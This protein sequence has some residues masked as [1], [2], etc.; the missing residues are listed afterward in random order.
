MF[1]LIIE[2]RGYVNIY[3]GSTWTESEMSEST[4]YFVDG[5]RNVYEK[6]KINL[7]TSDW[8]WHSTEFSSDEEMMKVFLEIK[9]WKAKT[10]DITNW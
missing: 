3:S 2:Q 5:E 8:R 10:I 6:A 9:E 7:R 4:N 1:D